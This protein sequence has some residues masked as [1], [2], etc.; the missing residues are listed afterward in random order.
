MSYYVNQRDVP[1]DRPYSIEINTSWREVT[2][3]IDPYWVSDDA[4]GHKHTAKALRTT[5]REVMEPCYCD[6]VDEPHERFVRWECRTCGEEVRPVVLSPC[7]IR[8]VP[9]R[10]TGRVADPDGNE[11]E[12]HEDACVALRQRINDG[13]EI[14]VEFLDSVGTQVTWGMRW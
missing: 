13:Q 8:T 3:G 14:N 4:A 1:M 2:G 11:W 9:D 5:L 10:T 6:V 7:N 12:L